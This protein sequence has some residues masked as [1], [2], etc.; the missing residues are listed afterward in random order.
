M[1]IKTKK[2]K[3]L[4]NS[5]EFYKVRTPPYKIFLAVAVGG[6]GFIIPDFSISLLISSALLSPIG[7]KKGFKNKI[8]GIKDKLIIIKYRYLIK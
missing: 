6:I 1:K 8:E 7:F 4:G 2:I 5:Y 3:W